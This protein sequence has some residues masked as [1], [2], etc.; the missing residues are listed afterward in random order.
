MLNAFHVGDDHDIQK[1]VAVLRALGRVS[2]KAAELAQL[3]ERLKSL[4]EAEQPLTDSQAQTLGMIHR[5]A[6]NRKRNTFFSF[7]DN[8]EAS[9]DRNG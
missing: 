4:Q 9:K 3:P 7:F 8:G 5:E 1:A 6:V 2:A